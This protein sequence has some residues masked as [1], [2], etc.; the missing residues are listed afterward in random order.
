MDLIRTLAAAG[1]V[2]LAL[3][4]LALTAPTP[5][6]ADA[7]QLFIHVTH[8]SDWTE[9]ATGRMSASSIDNLSYHGGPAQFGLLVI[10][11]G[12]DFLRRAES[13]QCGQGAERLGTNR[14]AGLVVKKL[15]YRVGAGCEVEPAD[16]PDS[17]APYL[18]GS[19]P[20]QAAE[21]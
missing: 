17:L 18:G 3:I 1:L 7:P 10:E 21:D 16:T 5:A 15:T 19:M 12:H 2:V 14:E 9:T 4:T 13:A 6:R 11:P 20:K 8:T